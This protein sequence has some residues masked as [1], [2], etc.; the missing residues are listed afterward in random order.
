[1][2][3]AFEMG[4]TETK[5]LGSVSLTCLCLHLSVALSEELSSYL[6]NSDRKQPMDIADYDQD[7][8]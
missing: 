6:A 2:R 3:Q 8:Y 1:M 7:I 5:R 4:E